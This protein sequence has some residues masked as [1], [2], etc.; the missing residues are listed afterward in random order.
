M[1][2]FDGEYDR[3]ASLRRSHR[4]QRP[5]HFQAPLTSVHFVPEDSNHSLASTATSKD[6]EEDVVIRN[7]WTP[8]ESEVEW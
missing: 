5:A 6:D 7:V 4:H 3:A 1:S 2:Y 8:E